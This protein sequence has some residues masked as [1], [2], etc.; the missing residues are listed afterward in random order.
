MC[1]AGCTLADN[2]LRLIA[3]AMISTTDGYAEREAAKVMINNAKQAAEN[4]NIVE[5]TMGADK[6]C[7][8]KG[9]V[10]AML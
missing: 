3:N 1:C 2:Q 8:V 4:E 10:D 7:Y 5:I 6:G 9:F